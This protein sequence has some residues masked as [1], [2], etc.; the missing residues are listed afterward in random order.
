MRTPLIAARAVDSFKVSRIE[1]ARARKTAHPGL[2]QCACMK[3]QVIEPPHSA[4]EHISVRHHRAL[5]RLTRRCPGG[6]QSA[7]ALR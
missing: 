1:L 7:E 3:P 2:T 5:P 4:T 6:A